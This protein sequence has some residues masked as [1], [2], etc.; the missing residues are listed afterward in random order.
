[1]KKIITL[2]LTAAI[3]VSSM[4]C[5]TTYDAYGNPRQSVD[6]VTAVAGVAAAGLLGYAL[7]S[8]NDSGRHHNT[9]RTSYTSTR[10]HNSYQTGYYD[11]HYGGHHYSPYRSSYQSY[12]Y[13]CY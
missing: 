8:N 10:Y 4:S 2:T 3:A 12:G 11:N 9:S 1:M 6:P 5:Q 13:H 7:S